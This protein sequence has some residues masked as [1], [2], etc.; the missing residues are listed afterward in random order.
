VRVTRQRYYVYPRPAQN[1]YRPKDKVTVDIKAMDANEAPISTDGTVKVTRDYWWEIW[2]DP[3]GREVKGE[4]LRILRQKSAVFPPLV[5]RGNR[6]W[7]LKFRGYEHEDILTQTVKTDTEG[8][9]QL[10]FVP[11]R[12]GYYRV[13]WQSS[14]GVDVKRDR[15]LPPITAETSV[16]VATNAT[17]DLGYRKGGLE[18][19][20]DKDTFR[21]GQ[22][23][24]VMINVPENDRYVL[25][26][27][28]ADD[29]YSYR[30][31]HVT[32][33]TKLIEVPVEERHVPNVYLSGSMV[34]DGNLFVRLKQVIVPPV[35]QFLAVAV[36]PDRE[37]Y[38][39]RE[40][41]TPRLPR[42]MW[43]VD[44]LPRRLHWV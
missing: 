11:D 37:Q 16:F 22:T 15:F 40:E 24:P 3:S 20:V 17:T 35:R 19:V 27:I 29:L 9:A 31:V 42:L 26:S 34:S 12:E 7:Q 6:Q 32:G 33:N 43:T 25:F 13:S 8:E 21:V 5:T 4:E 1:I 39:P 41:G 36:K 28:E 18:I 23:A 2:V 44:P 10:T 30:L 38:Q 14:Q